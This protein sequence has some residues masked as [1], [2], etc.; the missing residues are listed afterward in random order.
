VSLDQLRYFVTVADSGTTRE[1]ARR[2]HISQPPLSRQIRALEDEI[3]VDLFARTPRGMDLSPAGEVFLRHARSILAALDRAVAATR[4][5][6]REP[7]S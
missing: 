2:L 1:A 3:G 5:S 7:D 6:D 4:D